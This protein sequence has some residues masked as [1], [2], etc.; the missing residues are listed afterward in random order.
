MT[1]GL[2]VSWTMAWAYACVTVSRWL[3]ATLKKSLT[4]PGRHFAHSK[5]YGLRCL[6][7]ASKATWKANA[8]HVSSAD[9]WPSLVS[10]SDHMVCG[11]SMQAKKTVN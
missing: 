8:L 6:E 1:V 4:R 11:Y 10:A 7:M 9:K 5:L 3:G 2:L